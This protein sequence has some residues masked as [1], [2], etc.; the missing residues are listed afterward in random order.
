MVAVANK[1]TE[2]LEAKE[3]I[4]KHPHRYDPKSNGVAE[5]AVREFKGQLRAVKIALERRIKT[6][7][8]PKAPVLQ[9][10]VMHAVETINRFL[11]GADGETPW[12]RPE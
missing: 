6:N 1:V 4:L 7:I 10:M 2:C 3:I 12:I 5:R 8:E 9:W 11:V